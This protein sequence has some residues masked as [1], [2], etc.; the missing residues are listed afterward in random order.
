MAFIRLLSFL[1]PATISLLGVCFVFLRSSS[2]SSCSDK[3]H[4]GPSPVATIDDLF[5][6]LLCRE[7]ERER[8]R[9]RKEKRSERQ[10]KGGMK[11]KM[12][13]F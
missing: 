3:C 12:A 5:Q 11:R 10:R 9:E 2:S 1:S 4:S 6:S 8:E 13:A 7:R